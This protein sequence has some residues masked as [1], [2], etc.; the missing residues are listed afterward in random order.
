MDPEELKEI[1]E[2]YHRERWK[3]RAIARKL[4]RDP[5]TIRQALDLTHQEQLP[6]KLESFKPFIQTC[7]AQKLKAPRILREI[8]EKGYTGGMTI[9]KE[10][11]REIRGTQKKS[12]IVFQRFETKMAEE[13]QMDWSPYRILIGSVE[14]VVHC[15][16]LILCYSRRLWIGFF[17]NEKLPSLL[18]AHV[19]ALIYHRGSPERLVYDNQTTVTLGR[20]ARKPLW[21][22]T[23]LVFAK[24]YG[25][26]PFACRVRHKERKGKVE[27]PFGW[28]EDDFL[29]GTVFHSL[30]DLN[31]KV[32]VWLDTVANVRK[33]STTGRLV[34]AMYA[35]EQPFLIALPSVPFHAE[36]REVRKV[37][38]DGYVP[39]DGS[40]YPTPLKPGHQATILIYPNRVEILD[41][42]GTVVAAYPAADRPTRIAAP[43]Q[44]SHPREA[45]TLT[46][47]ETGFLGRFPRFSDFLEG[48]KRRMNALTPIHLRRIEGLVGIYGEASVAVAIERALSYRNF[49]ALALARILERAHP[50][51]IPEPPVD[52]LTANP[53]VLGALDEIDSGSPEDLTLDSKPPTEEDHHGEEE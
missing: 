15:F 45:T 1:K 33:H 17:R 46:A 11:L 42:A 31:Q 35:E 5:K 38:K 21:H 10:Y 28:I 12:T 34:D 39:V 44:S 4:G 47:L 26:K 22:P 41:A 43:W 32:R 40:F 19:E 3:I 48:L 24:H 51:V 50:N 52:Y 37:Q 8:R 13:G 25:F 16:S 14:T 27:R 2:L 18:Y 20:V 36:R 23:F 7:V 30:E 9:L 6:P 49:S 53:E 29:R